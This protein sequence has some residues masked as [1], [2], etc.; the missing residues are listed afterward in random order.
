MAAG[1]GWEITNASWVSDGSEFGYQL[2]IG[3]A[4]PSE[5][6]VPFTVANGTVSGSASG[7]V[8]IVKQAVLHLVLL[9][10]RQSQNQQ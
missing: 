10:C 4:L 7:S 5:L 2:H 1:D 3:H 8:T 9:H 6:V